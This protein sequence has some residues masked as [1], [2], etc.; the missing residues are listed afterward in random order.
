M[1]RPRLTQLSFLALFLA[2][3]AGEHTIGTHDPLKTGKGPE[4]CGKAFCADGFV[5]CNASCGICTPPGG[6]CTQQVCDDQPTCQP[7]TCEIACEHGFQKDADGCEICACNPPTCLPVTCE[8]AC[9]H[10]FQKDA[11]GCEVCACNPPP[12]TPTSGQCERSTGDAC[13]S[14]AD[15]VAGG[16]GGELCYNPAASGGISTCDC[17]A[18]Q[19]PACGCVAGRCTWYK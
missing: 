5:C 14:D 15:C 10:G 13:T 2:A 3:C 12:R 8:I 11:H 9:D 1:T 16:C 17:T 18:P 7:V 6:A 4:A 19:G